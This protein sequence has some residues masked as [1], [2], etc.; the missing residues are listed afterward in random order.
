MGEERILARKFLD[1]AKGLYKNGH[2][3]VA[4]KC[5]GFFS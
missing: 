5:L 3:I 1:R 2:K 4:G